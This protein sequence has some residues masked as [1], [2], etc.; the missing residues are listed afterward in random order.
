MRWMMLVMVSV[1]MWACDDSALEADESCMV[2]VAA[3]T[4]AG[5]GAEADCVDHDCNACTC[6]DGSLHCVLPVYYACETEAPRDL[7]GADVTW[8]LVSGEIEQ[9]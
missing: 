3:C 6:P 8:C 7:T 1:V 4:C 2:E 9:R 5:S